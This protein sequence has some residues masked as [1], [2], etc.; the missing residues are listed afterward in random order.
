MFIRDIAARVESFKGISEK[1]GTAAVYGIN[2][3]LVFNKWLIEA[4]V[5]HRGRPAAAVAEASAAVNRL[6]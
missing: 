6:A 1:Y 2:R 3:G 4:L 5:E